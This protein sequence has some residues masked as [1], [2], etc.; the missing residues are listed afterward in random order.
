MGIPIAKS[1]HGIHFDIIFIAIV[2]C[3]V[4]VKGTVGGYLIRINEYM[5][6][7]IQSSYVL[8]NSL[9]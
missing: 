6:N 7:V 2:N 3:R 8:I 5:S 1:S 9:V 4:G